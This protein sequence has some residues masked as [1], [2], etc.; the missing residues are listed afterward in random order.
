[1]SSIQSLRNLPPRQALY[2]ALQERARR[3]KLRLSQKQIATLTVPADPAAVSSLVMT[4][5]HPCHDLNHRNARYKILYGGHGSGKTWSVAEA[6]I[7]RAARYP[8]RV[9]CTREYQN[10]IKDSVHKVLGDQIT[11]RCRVHLPGPSRQRADDQVHG[12]C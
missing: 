10:S 11:F 9:L 4:P 6:L 5:G 8:I 3:E 7:R 12:R 1:M 2:L